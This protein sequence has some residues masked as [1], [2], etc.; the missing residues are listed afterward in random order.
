ME[1]KQRQ[2]TNGIVRQAK[3]A[4]CKEARIN[5]VHEKKMCAYGKKE[6]KVVGKNTNVNT[7]GSLKKENHQG[8]IKQKVEDLD[9]W[10]TSLKSFCLS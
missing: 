5:K 4:L 2:E 6:K 3:V 10:A 7:G 8:R 1:K 9:C